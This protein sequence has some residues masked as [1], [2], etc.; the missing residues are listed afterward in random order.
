MAVS[1][2]LRRRATDLGLGSF[3][4]RAPS[5]GP[6]R[7]AGRSAMPAR[8]APPT[9]G[10]MQRR[11][12][13]RDLGARP[14]STF[15]SA[16]TP[17][18]APPRM[19]SGS[20]WRGWRPGPRAEWRRPSSRRRRDVPSL[21]EPWNPSQYG[22]KPG[23]ECSRSSRPRQP[24]RASASPA[25]RGR[26]RGP[27]LPLGCVQG[28]AQHRGSE[29]SVAIVMDQRRPEGGTGSASPPPSSSATRLRFALPG[30]TSIWLPVSSGTLGSTAPTG[31]YARMAP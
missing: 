27:A 24:S 11:C 23:R 21:H 3:S 4:A 6:W 28:R 25:L 30:M 16:P 12:S 2:T 29:R 15:C 22:F 9:C 8:S 1:S 14:H 20:A 7:R 19:P 17:F 31:P 10:A 5:G 18:A 26:T 13:R